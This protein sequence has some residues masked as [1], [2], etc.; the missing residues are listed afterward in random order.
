MEMKPRLTAVPR[1]VTEVGPGDYVKTAS[2]W[3]QIASNTAFGMPR[4]PRS[5]SVRT[6]G[7]ALHG[8]WDIYAY[9]K[10]EDMEPKER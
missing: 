6:S 2:G 1:S 10:A 3:H 5:W 4:T 9:A 8:M 7:G